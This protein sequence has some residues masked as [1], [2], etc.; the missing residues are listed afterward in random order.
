MK[1]RDEI[2][3]SFRLAPSVLADGVEIVAPEEAAIMPGEIRVPGS[4]P[5]MQ[6][7]AVVCIVVLAVAL[8]LLWLVGRSLDRN[9]TTAS[10][11]QLVADLQVARATL[12]SDVA[13]ASRNASAIAHLPR[14]E[15][16]LARNDT[17]ALGAIVATHPHV[18][19]ISSGCA[20]AGPRTPLA[21]R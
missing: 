3:R 11:S 18:A 1:L 12:Q 17:T 16:A 5:A 2:E 20:H 15:E 13:I 19:L 7:I 4:R 6:R 9:R 14:V 10:N 8:A 21:V